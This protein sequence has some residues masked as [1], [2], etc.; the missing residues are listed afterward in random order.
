MT[1]CPGREQLERLL[2]TSRADGAGE[3]LERHVESCPS[4]QQVLESLTGQAD[5]GPG[6][7]D[8]PALGAGAAAVLPHPDTF[9]R[10]LQQSPPRSRPAVDGYEILGELGRGGMGIV[11]LARQVRLNRRCALKMILA[12]AHANPEVAARF[13]AEAEAIARLQHPH[14]VQIHHVGE[15][16][17]LPFIEL[18]YVSGGSLDRQLDGVPWT[19]G[20]AA[21]LAGQLASGVAE[22]HRLGIVHRDLKP[23]N[24]LLSADGAA[25][26][27]DFGL[28][29][30][31]GTDSGLTRT[32]SVIGSPSY[33]APEQAAGRARQ[34]G[35]A[36][37]I[38]AIGAILYEV[39]TG[40]PPF[41]G[42]TALET[43]EQVKAADPVSPSRLVPGLP[44]DLETICLKCLQKEPSQRYESS[45]ELAEDLGRFQAGRPIRARRT[46]S[47][48]RAWRWCR[49]NPVVAGLAGGIA[50]TLVLGT[51]VSTVLAIRADREARRAREEKARSDLRL[52]LAQMHLAHQAWR[53]GRLDLVAQH[54]D[55]AI[56][57]RRPEDRDPRG[58]EWY[59]LHRQCQLGRTLRGHEGTVRA[60]A[61][62]PDGRVLASAGADKTIRLWDSVNE[63]LLS[64]LRGHSDSVLA[65]AYSPDGRTLASGS[66]DRTLRI[67]DADRGTLLRTCE[68]HTDWVRGVEFSP[69]GRTIAS[70]SNDK[71]IG[72]W[73]AATGRSIQIMHGHAKRVSSVAFGPDGR[74]LAS[75]SDD[76]TIRL[77]D[78][79]TGR[80]RRRLEG[81]GAVVSGVAYSSDGHTLASASYDETVR[82]WD[83]HSGHVQVLPGHKGAARDVAF[84]PDGQR[85]ASAGN[86]G[87]VKVWQVATGELAQSLGGHARLIYRVAYSPD[88]RRIASASGDSTVKIRTADLDQA[89]TNLRGH[90][91]AVLGVAFSPDE[92][93]VASSGQDGT[94]RI[95]ELAT[96]RQL[97]TL[98]GHAGKV[99]AV[100]YS[101]DGSILA[102]CG[103]DHT[104]KLWDADTGLELRTLHGHA[105]MV[106]RVVFSPDGRRLAS[107]GADRTVRLWDTATGREWHTLRGHDFGVLNVV[108]SPDGR[109]LASSDTHGTIKLWDA[110]TGSLARTLHGHAGEPIFGVAYSPDGRDL[111][112]AGGDRTLKVWDAATGL[113]L[114]TL[115]GHEDWIE[116]LALSPDGRRIASASLDQTIRLWDCATGQE[117]LVLSGP[118]STASSLA[119][120]RDGLTLA[121]CWDDGILRLHEPAPM[122]GLDQAPREAW[123]LLEFLFA[124]LHTAAAVRDRLH[125]DPTLDSGLRQVALSLAEPYEEH[126]IAQESEHAV[127]KRFQAGMLPS[128]MLASLTEDTTLSQQVRA[129]ARELSVQLPADPLG[130]NA[131]S[132]QQVTRTD[133]EPAAYHRAL[134][135]AELACQLVPD[136]GE[137]LLTQGAA[138]YRTGDIGQAEATLMRADQILSIIVEPMEVPWAVLGLVY[139]RRGS[140]EEARKILERVSA[141]V[142]R[143]GWRPVVSQG[144]TFIRE[145]QALE[146]DL[147]FPADPFEP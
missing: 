109:N 46:S 130:L 56:E 86:D 57:F 138:Q 19:P 147:A 28:A 54:L 124:R 107:C 77:W 69:D 116:S 136:D 83:T 62:S 106:G 38:Y 49:R 103:Y 90:A 11:Y 117:L 59:F 110:A 121:C 128:E 122:T 120:G 22:A 7:E 132:W 37:D 30:A 4:C 141:I 18:E 25:K 146:Q 20:R 84:S 95:W 142:D 24:V 96:G 16:D 9:L 43:L 82:I 63:R 93:T 88:G 139:H 68:G 113:V 79:S 111:V 127:Q 51:T 15:A 87:K 125:H 112:T 92:R 101:P 47:P 23:G 60:V 45:A 64:T 31:L 134:R 91:G 2:A 145:L 14:I 36:A 34:V 1:R 114:Q 72:L 140:L 81:H 44:R 10:E 78:V 61:F 27:T 40:R 126:L 115:T 21:R 105:S 131:A 85:L 98:R 129:R 94:L 53:E 137:F 75:A 100:A 17:G 50:L 73:D 89:S 99:D 76:T 71:S 55:Q 35:P 3:E 26:I 41:R 119:F 135:Q 12:G 13:L 42:A 67:W 104:I 6:L 118:R 70:A 48:E 29:K 143:P 58:F 102:S 33:M 39:L 66:A 97:R 5:W 52:Y 65:I 133:G 74:T 32:D 80:E 144:L 8:W 123:G 108:F